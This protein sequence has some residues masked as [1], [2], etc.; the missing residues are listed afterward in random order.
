MLNSLAVL[1]GEESEHRSPDSR[2][3]AATGFHLGGGTYACKE[4]PLKMIF[5]TTLLKFIL[6]VEYKGSAMVLIL[7]LVMLQAC[8]IY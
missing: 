3:A 5:L 2:A 1:V 8:E 4:I 7:Y 6:M